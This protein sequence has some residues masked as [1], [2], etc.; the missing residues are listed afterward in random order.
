MY[1]QA[2]KYAQYRKRLG[3][4]EKD[5]RVVLQCPDCPESVHHPGFDYALSNIID[6]A[7]MYA[8]SNGRQY[9]RPLVI[10]T[11][12]GRER[13]SRMSK[14]EL[15]DAQ[16]QLKRASEEEKKKVLLMYIGRVK[17]FKLNR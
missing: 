16:R 1:Q 4:S 2:E 17:P 14:S 9:W 7:I 10:E 13:W 11:W 5:L 12:S 6:A 3:I 15:D 8:K